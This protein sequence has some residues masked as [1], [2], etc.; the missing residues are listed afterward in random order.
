ME[1]RYVIEGRPRSAKNSTQ[2]CVNRKTGQRFVR[3]SKAAGQ[4]QDDAIRQLAQQ[5]GRAKTLRGPVFVDYTVFQTAD[6][7]DID[8]LESALFDAL[9]KARVIEDDKLIT[10]HAGRKRI[11]RARPRF[12]IVIREV[13]DVA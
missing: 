11:D 4:W 1:W 3:K 12:E 8:N 10:D 7:A 13:R 2:I 9:K 6:V 5:R